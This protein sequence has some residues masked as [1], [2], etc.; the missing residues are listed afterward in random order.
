LG[1]IANEYWF[2]IPQ[3]YAEVELDEFIIMPNH[4]HGIIVLKYISTVET[5]NAPSLHSLGDV[6]GSF[7]SGIPNGLIRMDIKISNGSHALITG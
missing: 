2:N 7:K 3:H 1:K 6:V 4:V 5:G